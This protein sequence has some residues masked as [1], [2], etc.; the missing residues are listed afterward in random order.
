[1]HEPLQIKS[2]IAPEG[3]KGYVYIEAY[4]QT[5]VKQAIEGIGNLRIGIYKQQMVPIT[6]MTDVLRVTKE[7]VGLKPKQ[8]VRL[9]R[10]LY[11]DDIAQIDYVDLAQN[12]VHLKLLPRIDYQ[13]MRGALRDPKLDMD[14]KRKKKRRPV[15]KPFNP[16]EIRNIGGEITSD[17]DFLLF[18]SN[19]YSH[20]G[21]LYKTF[22]ITAI[23]TDGVA[24]TLAELERF[25]E[26]PV[27][28]LELEISNKTAE[29]RH[30]FATGDNVQVVEGELTNLQGKILA[31]D[32]NKITIQPKHEDLKD[33]LDFQSQELEKFF[34]QGDHVR[35]ISGK[36]EGDTGL[37]VRVE[38]HCAYL[39]S[40]LTMHEL[41]VLPKDLQ[42]C[43]DMASGVDSM[44]HFQ[45][46]DL[47]QIDPNTVGVIVRLEKELFHVL[48]MTGKVV[49][50][51]PQSIQKRRESR[52]VLG[53]D[54]RQNTIQKRD[55][56]N[57]LDGAH[58]VREGEI[59]HIYRNYA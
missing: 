15:A 16:D 33:A 24:P 56:V 21:F 37:I 14:L 2:V 11:K 55:I 36:Y 43:S 51:K 32:G 29:D 34:V 42:L 26:A 7:Q 10:G 13:R 44:G 50:K 30:A 53:V 23:V 1:A 49:E 52:H 17:G 9:K 22:S 41:K 8:W 19:R 28:G 45:W 6:E 54:S 12:Q 48:S 25:N 3:I 40:D 5:H 20:K 4:K 39:F 57:V 18:E 47:V 58:P 38:P 59:R 27:E 31:I 35:V 46:G